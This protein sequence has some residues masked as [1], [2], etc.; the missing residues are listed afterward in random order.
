MTEDRYNMAKLYESQNIV[1]DS[2]N[3]FEY[4]PLS[5]ASMCEYHE[6]TE[7]ITNLSSTPVFNKYKNLRSYFH[8]NCRGISSNWDKFYDLMCDLHTDNFF[9]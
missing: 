1:D 5:D 7:L 6:P 8:I 2:E 4:S 3:S 9:F